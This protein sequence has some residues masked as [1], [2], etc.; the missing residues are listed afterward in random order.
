[1]EHA[2]LGAGTVRSEAITPGSE[3]GAEVDDAAAVQ[4]H[5]AGGDR[6]RDGVIAPSGTASSV[7]SAAATASSG[8]ATASRP[9][10]VGEEARHLTA[11]AGDGRNAISSLVRGDRERGTGATGA[12]DR[13][14]RRLCS[15]HVSVLLDPSVAEPNR[16][17]VA[18]GFGLEALRGVPGSLT[19]DGHNGRTA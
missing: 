15:L 17:P 3:P 8:V 14:R 10:G 12:D 6:R 16:L 5:A 19:V 4:R 1:M 18:G 7:M 13:Q 2:D 9:D 11:P